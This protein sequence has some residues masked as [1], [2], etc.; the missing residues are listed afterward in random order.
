MTNRRNTSGARWEHGRR[1][2][3]LFTWLVLSLIF[4]AYY[5]LKTHVG[6]NSSIAQH[7]DLNIAAPFLFRLLLPLTLSSLMPHDWLDLP[8]TRIA[9]ATLF[10]FAS[11]C[12][13]PAF[14]DRVTGSNLNAKEANRA[15]LMML[16]MLVAHYAL[17]RNLMF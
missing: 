7:A 1:N 9:V 3:N 11:I 10:S 8:T 2:L 12:L 4:C 16:V 14:M 13:M 17:P 6:P 5:V 15:R